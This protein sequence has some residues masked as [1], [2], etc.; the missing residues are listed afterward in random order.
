M[1]DA[2]RTHPPRRAPSWRLRSVLLGL[3]ILVCGGVIVSV[4]TTRVLWRDFRE[5]FMHPQRFVDRMLD[6]L[7]SELHLQGEQRERVRGIVLDHAVRMDADR[8]EVAPRIERRMKELEE[9][10][11]R[12]LDEE[13]E[14]AWRGMLERMRARRPKFMTEECPQ[15]APDTTGGRIPRRR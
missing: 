12:E 7:D 15:P 14:R 1:A 2:D 13:Q 6:D 10:V 5:E 11:A 3:A 4:I 8:R 9:S